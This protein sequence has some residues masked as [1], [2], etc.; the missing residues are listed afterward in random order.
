VTISIV[1][2]TFNR[3]TLL[4]ECLEHLSRQSFEPGDEVI[5][6]DN[7]STDGT[8]HVIDA[9]ASRFPVPL[10]RLEEPA[11][12]KSIAVARGVTAASGDVL[13]FTDDDVNVEDGWL[14]AVRR[15]MGDPAVALI[16]G[17]VAPRWEQSPPSWLR[18]ATESYG[19]L[20]AP[21]A[22]LDYGASVVDLGPRTVLGANLAVRREAFRLAGGFSAHLGKLRGT[23]LSGEDHELCRRVQAAGLRA[24]YCPEARVRHWVPAARMRVGYY[25]G[26]FFWSGIT[27]ATIDAGDASRR[28]LLF[29]VPPYIARR[30]AAGVLAAIAALA[31]W[32]IRRVIERISDVA[33]AAGYASRSIRLSAA[34]P[35]VPV[36]GEPR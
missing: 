10:H 2:A 28:R 34:R 6:V 26:W 22:L 8:K 16:G 36:A 35:P 21:V 9:A 14:G 12:G 32:N 13:A 1:I 17:P 27:H 23:L 29:G 11:P 18:T 15:A 30:A 3:A 7:G 33:F 20:A 19:P 31:A 4:A 25:L 5:V 24:T